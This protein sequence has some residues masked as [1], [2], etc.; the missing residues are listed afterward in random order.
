M[1]ALQ[2]EAKF[3]L[4]A[5]EW[6]SLCAT[7][8]T[9]RNA[10]RA[11]SL[12]DE[13]I[14][15][16]RA[17]CLADVETPAPNASK[18]KF[19]RIEAA[20]KKLQI[21]LRS[22]DARERIQLA[23]S[24]AAEDQ[25]LLLDN[26]RELWGNQSPLFDCL[27]NVKTASRA[28]A[29]ELAPKKRGVDSGNRMWLVEQLHRDLEHFGIA[30]SGQGEQFICTVLMIADPKIKDGSRTVRAYIDGLRKTSSLRCQ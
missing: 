26:M 21:E 24:S 14:S 25:P 16:F 27:E 5:A 17:F 1:T 15:M 2:P 4:S 18:D 19:A 29:E 23:R 13:R 22:L 12:I 7:L 28:A 20:A 10:L 11:R 6:D 8:P 3:C 30:L 9:L